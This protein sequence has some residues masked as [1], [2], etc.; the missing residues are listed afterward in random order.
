MTHLLEKAIVEISKL[1]EDQQDAVAAWILDELQDE[2]AWDASFASS[3][4]KLA[5]LAARARED[6]RAGRVRNAGFD[7][8]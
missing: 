5:K 7:E 6:R 3:P 1:P 4:D 8:L 2:Q